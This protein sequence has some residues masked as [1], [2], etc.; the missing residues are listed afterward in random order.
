MVLSPVGS[1]GYLQYFQCISSAKI[2]TSAQ[3][4]PFLLEIL[5]I[6]ET[7]EPLPEMNWLSRRQLRCDE[8]DPRHRPAPVSAQ[9]AGAQHADP[10]RPAGRC[11]T[12]HGQPQPVTGS[13]VVLTTGHLGHPPENCGDENPRSMC[14]RCHAAHDAPQHRRN[15]GGDCQ[16]AAPPEI[17]SPSRPL[18]ASQ[19][20]PR[21]QGCGVGQGEQKR[22]QRA[23]AVRTARVCS[24]GTATASTARGCGWP[25]PWPPDRSARGGYPGVGT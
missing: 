22:S 24:R 6:L 11:T 9:L 1:Q 15:G 25:R 18:P 16:P 17:D 12:R 13:R 21:V 8:P 20:V 3:V 14:Q 23:V 7:A 2:T 5:E 19:P 10:V 4:K